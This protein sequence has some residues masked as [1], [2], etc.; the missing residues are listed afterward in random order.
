MIALN[1][2]ENLSKYIFLKDTFQIDDS[3]FIWPQFPVYQSEKKN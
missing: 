1:M 3:A 2:D